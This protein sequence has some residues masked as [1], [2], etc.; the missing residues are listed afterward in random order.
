M[1][2]WIKSKLFT[3]LPCVSITE[4]TTAKSYLFVHDVIIGKNQVVLSRPG[5]VLSRPGVVLSRPG[6]V[7]SRPGVFL[8]RVMMSSV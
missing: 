7:L 8:P 1:F 6:V 5:V 3:C 2:G 4:Q